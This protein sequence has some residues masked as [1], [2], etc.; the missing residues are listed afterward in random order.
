MERV[1]PKHGRYS[2]I[3]DY[4]IIGDCRSSALISRDGSVDWL[5]LPRF[6]SPS[7]FADILDQDKGGSFAI[8]PTAKYQSTRRY[9][10]D[11]NVLETTFTTDEGVVTLTDL[12]PVMSEE[13]KNSELRP[14]HELLRILECKSGQVDVEIICDPRPNYGARIPNLVDRGPFGWFYEHG[15]RALVLRSEVPLA[16]R[17]H[18]PGVF[19]TA[20]LRTGERCRVSLS[21]VEAEPAV[22]PILGDYAEARVEKSI[23]WWR[24]WLSRC[25][26]DG[27]FRSAVT[28][29]V[30]TLKMMTYAPSGAVVAAPTT[31]LPEKIG[32]VRNWD[33]RYC[34]LRDASFTLRAMLDLGYDLEAEAFLSWMLHA[35]RLTW[36]KLQ[37][38]Y[39]VYGET[40][41]KERLLKKLEGYAGSHPVRVGN[42][43]RN[44]LQLDIY[45]EVV[46]ATLRFVKRGGTLDRVSSRM[47][48]GF[49]ET[50]YKTW[51]E[52]DEGIWEP[53][54]GRKHNTVSKA[55]CWVAMQRLVRMHAADHVRVPTARFANEAEVM[56]AEIETRG[57]N[58][59]LGSYVAHYDSAVVDA[60]LLLMGLHGYADVTGDRMKGTLRTVR[61]RLGVNGLMYRYLDED[62]LPDREGAFALC[63]YWE[64]QLLAAM[65][66]H[67][68][69]ESKLE[70]ALK[71][72]N[73]VGL[74][75]EEIDPH[76]GELLGNFP[77]AYTHVGVINCAVKLEEAKGKRA[78][79]P[80]DKGQRQEAQTQR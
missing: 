71:Y 79:P 45:G 25:T 50:V 28:R 26:Y 12:M 41:L 19:G 3:A 5:C 27:E 31:S 46:D 37:I 55:M 9:I 47:V 70:H 74:L 23:A 58:E 24:G 44:Q 2:P 30:L 32:G 7:L 75:A 11:T 63:T 68:E 39:D 62:G 65:G 20:K 56:R 6:D 16:R 38:M 10:P 60:S 33:Y 43:A 48:L 1:T 76:T 17:P 14:A 49:G 73:D 69:A 52:P 13:E 64:I 72:A 67:D 66:A 29:S 4:A 18:Q 36:P 22:L 77:Q 35:T 15:S 34:W 61:E 57:F 51:C 42:G 59:K 78:A 8:R 40:R 53:R 80:E 54:S 21:F